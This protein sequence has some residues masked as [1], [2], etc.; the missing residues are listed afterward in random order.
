MKELCVTDDD[1][2]EMEA[3]GISR[4]QWVLEQL[5]SLEFNLERP[6]HYR[7]DPSLGHTRI[8]QYEY[9]P[10]L[11]AT[12]QDYDTELSSDT[13]WD[14]ACELLLTDMERFHEKAP[15][16]NEGICQHGD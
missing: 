12:Q 16:H 5:K 9:A 7:Y 11:S 1:V 13:D 8:Y 14:L 10:D 2:R 3:L 15:S 6:I 4:P